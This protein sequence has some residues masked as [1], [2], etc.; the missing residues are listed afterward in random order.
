MIEADYLSCA[1]SVLRLLCNVFDVETA[2]VTL[3]T[4]QAV[5]IPYIWWVADSTCCQL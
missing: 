1:E 2:A 3:L 5:W 4:G